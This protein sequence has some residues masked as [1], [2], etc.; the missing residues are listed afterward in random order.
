MNVQRASLRSSGDIGVNV[1]LDSRLEGDVDQ[2]SKDIR[3]ACEKL[4]A[5]LNGGGVYQLTKTELANDML[6]L[7]PV[8]YKELVDAAVAVI[9]IQHVDTQ[10]IGKK[11]VKRVKAFIKGTLRGL[12]EYDKGDRDGPK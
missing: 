4:T 12:E 7:V 10:K 5:F 8:D 11:N 1:L 2:T 6:S 9:S 3:D